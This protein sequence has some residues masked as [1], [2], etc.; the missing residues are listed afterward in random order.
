MTED[1]GLLL[2]GCVGEAVEEGLGGGALLPADDLLEDL[3]RAS[4]PPLSSPPLRSDSISCLFSF[5]FTG[6]LSWLSRSLAAWPLGLTSIGRLAQPKLLRI[7]RSGLS[8]KPPSTNCTF[9][10][11]VFD[12]AVFDELVFDEL[13]GSPF[14]DR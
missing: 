11:L 8:T 5:L 6:S 10:E 3:G 13:D 12:E 9:D 1:F 2:A 14:W 7:R 4:S